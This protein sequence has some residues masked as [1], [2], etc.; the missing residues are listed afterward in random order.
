MDR[1]SLDWGP[2]LAAL[3]I[4]VLAGPVVWAALLETNYVLSYVACE[5]RHTWM[6]HVATAAALLLIALAALGAWRAA[7]AAASEDTATFEARETALIRARFMAIGGLALCGFF[8]I[9]VL[10]AEIPVLVLHPC[11]R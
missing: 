6:L 10:A 2:R 8:A 7:P 4:G 1:G 3:W 11:P 5:S 9:A